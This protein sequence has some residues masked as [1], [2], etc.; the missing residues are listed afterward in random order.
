MKKIILALLL[1]V[2]MFSQKRELG[3]VTIKELQEAKHPIDTSAVAAVLFEKGKTMFYYNVEN[4]FSIETEVE[5]KIKIYKKE[6]YDWATKKVMYSIGNGSNN[7]SV[8]FSKANTFNLVNGKIVKTKLSND[9]EFQEKTNEYWATKKITMPNV[10]EGSIIEYKYVVKSPYISKMDNWK[11]QS[12]IPVNYSEYM[13]VIPEFYNYNTYSRGF[14]KINKQDEIKPRKITYTTGK[15]QYETSNGGQMD[16]FEFNETTTKYY[17]EN[18]PSF[19]AEAFSN[20]ITN[21]LSSIEFELSST[22][23][24][25]DGVRQLSQSWEDATKTIYENESFGKELD[26]NNYYEEDLKVLLNEKFETDNAKINKIYEF[27]KNR[28]KWNDFVGIFADKGVKNAYQN[29]TGNSAEIN[30]ILIS[31]LRSAGF[32]A[33]PILLT[34]R[35][36]AIN[37]F[38]SRTAYNYVICGVEVNNA[39]ILLDATDKNATF[40]ILPIRDMNYLGRIIRKHGSSAEIDL[41]PLTSSKKTILSYASISNDGKISG[42]IK[43]I[44]S[45]TR[46]Y[47]FRRD[48]GKVSEETYLE[49]FE[50]ENPGFE[51]KDYK[52]ENKENLLEPVKEE[53]SF[54][55]S[56]EIESIDGKYYFR[57]MLLFAL[58]NN[59]FKAEKR[60]YPIDFIYP[61]SDSYTFTYTIPEGYVV[62]SVPTNTNI[63]MVD[64]IMNFKFMAG[65]TGGKVQIVCNL[66]TN[67]SFLDAEY[68]EDLKAFY[69]QA[70]LKMNEKIILKKK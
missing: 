41:S 26:K 48:N 21:Y 5:V 59:P 44:V 32:T 27:V 67:V 60:D 51:I 45:D 39:V 31:M 7:E 53:Y 6:G 55:D 22:R 61:T 36:K 43:E 58:D 25:N 18:I 29:K 57:P 50:K 35:D 13:T 68:Y 33:N 14:Q 30:F 16:S 46:A 56:K 8:S 38:P 12:I 65:I 20:T 3:E 64:N 17:V 15:G 47:I 40:N 66:N 23:F 28:M 9:G 1:P 10:K 70:F 19:K 62:E 63:A 54:E 42:N 37:L 34:T 4:G 24:P 52:I 49:Q 2:L 69:N 11:F